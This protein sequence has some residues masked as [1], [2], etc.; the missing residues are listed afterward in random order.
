MDE[1]EYNMQSNF[2]KE[3]L[4][5]SPTRVWRTYSGG[6]VMEKWLGIKNPKDSEFPEMWA[7]STV[8][9]INPMSKDAVDEG[10]S[11]IQLRNGNCIILKEII[12]S[13][14]SGFLGEEHFNKFGNNMGVLAKIIDSLNR[15]AIQ[16]HPD[17][18][19]A[20]KMFSSEY[21]KTESWYVLG[22]RELNG[23][24]PHVYLGFKPD[25]TRE[26]WKSLFKR[27]DIEGMLN[28]LHKVYVKP[29]DVYFISGGVPHAIGAGCFLIEIQEP[30]DYTLRVERKT[31][32][33]GEITDQLCHQG[34][35]FDKL[36]DCFHYEGL[37]K[38]E[39]L[40]KWY[41]IPQKVN[42]TSEGSN[43]YTM[44]SYDF[45]K[46]F[47]MIKFEVNGEYEK[48]LGENFSIAI[49]SKGK[50]RIEYDG[51]SLKIKQGDVLF[52]PALINKIKLITDG[53]CTLEVILCLPPIW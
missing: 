38:D 22:G 13:D 6:M 12:D 39:M 41:L 2:K 53:N 29:G 33:G 5:I 15:L 24:A 48:I 9:S 25:I 23:E 4:K 47:S 30:T 10:L 40:K 1:E 16:V 8:K 11:R 35:G 50:G 43:E 20:R 36:F 31:T 27:Q 18:E 21:G 46:L 34:L 14:P 28:C 51:L 37:T 49:V 42:S 7:A 19:F 26:K 32:D 17:K 45:T 52:I 44:I 3:I